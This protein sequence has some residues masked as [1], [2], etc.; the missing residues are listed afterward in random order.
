VLL[1]RFRTQTQD[2]FTLEPTGANDGGVRDQ[3]LDPPYVCLKVVLERNIDRDPKDAGH[4]K[5]ICHQVWPTIKT[6]NSMFRHDPR[7]HCHAFGPQHRVAGAR[8][9]HS[10]PT[11]VRLDDDTFIEAS[12]ERDR[13]RGWE[14]RGSL[15]VAPLLNADT[16]CRRCRR[17]RRAARSR[18]ERETGT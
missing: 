6:P 3:R 18:A 15:P 9:R 1:R 7:N 16:Q 5:A 8:H 11:T 14:E 2:G 4:G 17:Q 10:V 12:T 13:H